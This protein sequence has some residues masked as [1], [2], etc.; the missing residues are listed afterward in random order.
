ME[1]ATAGKGAGGGERRGMPIGDFYRDW[2]RASFG[3]TMAEPAGAIF[4]KIDGRNLHEPATWINGPGGIKV[5]KASWETVKSRYAFVDEL[6]ALRAQVK[7]AGNVERFDYWLNTY[8]FMAAM[9]EVGCL[10]GQLDRAMDAIKKAPDAEKKK[11]QA[12]EALEIRL[13][14]AR[15]WERMMSC[16]VAAA[17]TPGDLG[18]I[19]NLEQHN[20]RHQKF[21]EKHDPDLAAALGAP[22]PADAA[23]GLAYRGPA[24][25]VVPTLRSQAAPGE[26]LS[27]KVILL[28]ADDAPILDGPNLPSVLALIERHLEGVLLARAVRA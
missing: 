24:R 6:A 16:Q 25:I 19:C 3:E 21:I 27:I 15:V 14:L 9:A 17:D 5:E 20:R 18:T 11:S 22:L 2:A 12:R 26:P 8:R 28:A 23:P 10:R 13:R 1:G 4:A 7:G